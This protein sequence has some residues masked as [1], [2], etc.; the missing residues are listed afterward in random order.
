MDKSNDWNSSFWIDELAKLAEDT[1]Y[2]I[3]EDFSVNKSDESTTESED[4]KCSNEL[5]HSPTPKHTFGKLIEPDDGD[6]SN[7]SVES[8]SKVTEITPSSVNIQV[9]D[10]GFSYPV[11][12]GTSNAGHYEEMNFTKSSGEATRN[13]LYTTEIL[14]C[15]LND[16]I[17]GESGSAVIKAAVAKMEEDAKKF[18]N[19]QVKLDFPSFKSFLAKGELSVNAKSFVPLS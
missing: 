12:R 4:S 3:T 16:L 17:L 6:C 15:T 10:F 13:K 11:K 7:K 9:T 14:H 8:A 5:T 2:A 18:K 1:K 19:K